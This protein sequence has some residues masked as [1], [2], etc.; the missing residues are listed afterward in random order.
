MIT[1]MDVLKNQPQGVEM[2]KQMGDPIIWDTEGRLVID[3]EHRTEHSERKSYQ[4][5]IY[6][7]HS[8]C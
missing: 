2:R 8:T 5:D 7:W 4:G 6:G 3:C 1:V